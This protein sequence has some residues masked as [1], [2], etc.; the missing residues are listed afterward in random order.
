MKLREITVGGLPPVRAVAPPVQSR[1][2]LPA[3]GAGTVVTAA[4]QRGLSRLLGRWRWRVAIWSA[5]LGSIGRLG[6]GLA[7]L[8]GTFYLAS[9]LPARSTLEEQD[10]QVSALRER[11]AQEAQ[12]AAQT[13]AGPEDEL[14][15]FYRILPP[16]TGVS[17]AFRTI[18]RI[19]VQQGLQLEHAEYRV[20]MEG[21]GRLLRYEMSFPVVG[22]YPQ[23][24]MFLRQVSAA[25]PAAV[26]DKVEFAYQD[27]KEG[28]VRATIRLLLYTKKDA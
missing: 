4:R 21:Q 15:R 16:D 25:I 12:R 11:L 27:Q 14:D 28:H 2:Q 1:P 19:G 10:A 18:Y 7:V 8:G 24:R 6:I 3:I 17:D 9:V 26:P 22:T 20:A 5:R 13:P 23:V